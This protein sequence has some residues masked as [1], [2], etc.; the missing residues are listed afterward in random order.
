MR[1][2]NYLHNLNV[3]DKLIILIIYRYYDANLQ[4][5][6]SVNFVFIVMT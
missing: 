6:S 5:I 2:G 1:S 4:A 3:I